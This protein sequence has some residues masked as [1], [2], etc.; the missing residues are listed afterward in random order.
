MRE[1]NRTSGKSSINA[2]SSD[3]C[4]KFSDTFCGILAFSRVA[5]FFEKLRC[6]EMRKRG[7]LWFGK[8]S[9]K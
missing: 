8:K 9:K 1:A 3:S 2:M 6:G 5:I 4:K 7:V